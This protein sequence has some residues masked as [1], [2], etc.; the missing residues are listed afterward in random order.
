MQC[1]RI[2]IRSRHLLWLPVLA[3]ALGMLVTTTPISQAHAYDVPILVLADDEDPSSVKGSGSIFRDFLSDFA[4]ALNRT[5]FRLIDEGTLFADLRWPA[6]EERQ[7]LQERLSTHESI[8]RG[9]MATGIRAA[10]LLQMRI[11]GRQRA[12]RNSIS[13]DV[14]GQVFN[15]PALQ[16]VD[17]LHMPPFEFNIGAQ[18]SGP[19]V[20]DAAKE[21][22]PEIAGA[23]AA[24]LAKRWSRLM[25][26]GAAPGGSGPSTIAADDP[27][28][29]PAFSPYTITLRN[30]GRVDTLAF[31]GV[32]VEEFPGYQHH[33][34]IS[35]DSSKAQYL[36]ET[37]ASRAKLME[38][39]NILLNDMSLD[40]GDISITFQG[41]DL[42]IE[43][44]VS[45]EP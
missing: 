30:F 10:V 6:P 7:P 36:Y 1:P 23:L 39:I 29:V 14:E 24:V 41:D 12:G 32:M 18:C 4:H 26:G 44:S 35:L 22:F 2:T 40:E 21:R 5:G 37:S 16:R 9:G 42:T 19:C 31:I 17:V 28:Y 11:F 15:Y 27:A 25:E 45:T 34:L 33:D 13:L 43:K 8:A 38:W 20:A 3:L